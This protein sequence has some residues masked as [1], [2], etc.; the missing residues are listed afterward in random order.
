MEASAV[1]AAAMTETALTENERWYQALTARWARRLLRGE[2]AGVVHAA[3]PDVAFAERVLGLR[4]G[5]RV[6]DLACGWGR[7]SI[8]LA[9]RGYEVIA[10]DLSP[11]LLAIGRAR[12]EA[13]DVAVAFVEG[14][15]RSLA[16]LSRFDAVCAFYD[17]CLVA[18]AEEA[19]N[20]AAIARVARALRPGGR[21]LFGTTDCPPL[22]PPEQ[23][24]VR[25]EDGETIE[26]T[27]R[28]DTAS[29]TGTSERLHRLAG[30]H[31]E[32]YRRVRRHHSLDEVTVLLA[33]AKLELVG[34]WNSYDEALP[35]GS[36]PEG[37]VVAAKLG[38]DTR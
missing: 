32:R 28:F 26:E 30:G 24:C 33:E 15:A 21:L 10:L 3:G 29:R 6:L 9:R 1:P 31:V 23:R 27:I 2:R 12:A 11:D 22:L 34:A 14:T 19:D 38:K 7:T 25:R 5:M 37:M 8:E 20:R 18:Y 35:F 16:D 36:R 4:P 17:D 13:A